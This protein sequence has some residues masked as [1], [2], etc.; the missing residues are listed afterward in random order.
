MSDSFV[1]KEN[2]VFKD[3][4]GRFLTQGLFLEYKQSSYVPLFTL[5]EVDVVKNGVTYRSL[6]KLYLEMEDIGEYKFA[7]TYLYSW[8]HW[9]RICNNRCLQ[10]HIETWR[11]ELEIKLR[12][13]ALTSMLETA[14]N[15]GAKGTTAAKYILDRGYVSKEERKQDNNKEEVKESVEESL[16]TSFLQRIK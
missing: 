9:E 4:K 13:K 12:G 8:Q 6:K 14:I 16:A 10:P 15:E 3:T 7:T 1:S 2:T 11:K 5:K